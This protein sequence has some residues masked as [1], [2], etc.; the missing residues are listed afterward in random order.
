MPDSGSSKTACSSP[1]PASSRRSSARQ[2]RA[3]IDID[4]APA[5]AAESLREPGGSRA[6][7]PLIS[8]LTLFI[9]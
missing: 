1:C 6:L 7:E 9:G 5:A 2:H 3:R 8:R 4:N